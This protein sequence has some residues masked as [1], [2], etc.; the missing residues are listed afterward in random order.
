[1]IYKYGDGFIEVRSFA[2]A[3]SPLIQLEI[4]TH[5]LNSLLEVAVSHQL[6]FGNNEGESK[7]L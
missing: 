6:V 1:M 5:G 4:A 3:E 7:I 2:A